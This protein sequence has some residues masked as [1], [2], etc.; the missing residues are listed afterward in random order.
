MEIQIEWDELRKRKVFIATPCYGGMATVEYMKSILG[1]IQFCTQNKIPCQ[2]HFMS[3]ESLIPRA[4]N[5]LTDE[6]LRSDCTHLMFIDADIGFNPEH[7]LFLLA[8]QNPDPTVDPYD[9]IAVPYPKKNISW[10]KIKL[11]VNKGAAD[12]DP[13][14]LANFVGDFV[15][16]P[17][18][19]GESYAVRLDEPVEISE[20]GTGFMMIRRATLEKW[21]EAYPQQRYI[22]D[23][24]RSDAF[25]GTREITAY[26]DCVID[27]K[28]IG[29]HVPT[30]RYLSE[31]Y[32]F[33]HYA[34]FAGMKVYMCPWMDLIH[35]G[36]YPFRGSLP[37]LAA[38]GADGSA[39][40]VQAQKHAKRMREAKKNIAK[41]QGQNT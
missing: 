1:L 40:E 14:N 27:D 4:R 33:C 2:T 28:P 19:K 34:R 5:Y 26:F 22:P 38:I 11:A 35:Y 41:L 12:D 21:N 39:I 32:M 37:H 23:S 16:N 18:F 3:N 17:V 24:P 7:V 25:D 36:T 6:F 31:D 13:E 10:E 15:F 20:A 8:L 29:D 30:R 9:V